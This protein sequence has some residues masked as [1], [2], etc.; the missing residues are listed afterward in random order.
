MKIVNKQQLKEIL[1]AKPNGGVI[2]SDYEPNVYNCNFDISVNDLCF[3]ARQL[4]PEP[5]ADFPELPYD[6]N[7][8]EYDEEAQFVVLENEDILYLI[9]NLTIGLNVTMEVR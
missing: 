1:M 4:F 8:E 3:G 9:K 7:I 6:W 2:F 5:F